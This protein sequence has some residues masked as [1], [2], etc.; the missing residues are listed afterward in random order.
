MKKITKGDAPNSLIRHRAQ[1]FSNFNNY[2]EK[3]E[4]SEALVREQ[5]GLCCYCTNRIESNS[6]KM[7]IEHWKCRANYQQLELDYSNLLGACLGNKDPCGHCDRRKGDREL[8]WNPSDPERNIEDQI[9]YLNDGTIQSIDNEFNNQ[10]DE[11]LNLNANRLKRNRKAVYDEVLKWWKS[12][13]NA[14]QRIR[15]Q[16]A[17]HTGDRPE[18][19]SPVAVWFLRCKL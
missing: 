8:K 19:F 2:R 16:I 17:V 1:T 11:I 4:L 3:N 13:P 10:I 5:K 9:Q 14:R 12:T 15:R 6:E 7:R 18:P